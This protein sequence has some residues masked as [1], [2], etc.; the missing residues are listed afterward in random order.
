MI[1]LFVYGEL[2]CKRNFQ[3]I[4]ETPVQTTVERAKLL[5]HKLVI[6]AGNIYGVSQHQM[7]S[8]D[9]LLY[10]LT[11]DQVQSIM[12]YYGANFRL[13]TGTAK[14][15]GEQRPVKY[16]LLSTGVGY[17]GYCTKELVEERLLSTSALYADN[18]NERKYIHST[19]QYLFPARAVTWIASKYP[20]YVRWL[21]SVGYDA[22]Y[23][24][25]NV[26][27][28]ESTPDQIAEAICALY[29]DAVGSDR[30]NIKTIAIDGYITAPISLEHANTIARYAK[31]LSGEILD[32][33]EAMAKCQLTIPKDNTDYADM[34]A[35]DALSEICTKAIDIED[36][37]TQKMYLMCALKLLDLPLINFNSV[38]SEQLNA[39]IINA[40]YINNLMED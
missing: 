14:V 17:S 5:G 39:Y 9:G 30:N 25:P 24:L 23:M 36:S 26:Q 38:D 16:M 31:V 34:D 20:Y 35:Y 3:L 33:N 29:P 6:T 4:V 7:S 10:K 18:E 11:E 27:G 19:L 1:S 8:V 40:L 15:K 37:I 2:I 12:N 28:L 22:K 13:S 21:R 32:I